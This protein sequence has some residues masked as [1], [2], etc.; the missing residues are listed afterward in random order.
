MAS[1]NRQEGSL[2][3]ASLLRGRLF[4]LAEDALLSEVEESGIASAKFDISTPE[5]GGY[6]VWVSPK[7]QTA[8]KE[9]SPF[10]FG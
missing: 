2:L 4:D 6:V 9:P 3:L 1:E 8:G 7:Y 5:D 10:G